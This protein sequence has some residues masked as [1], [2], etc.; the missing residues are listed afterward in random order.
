M[1]KQ[2]SPLIIAA[3]IIIA[4]IIAIFIPVEDATVKNGIPQEKSFI[5]KTLEKGLIS[6]VIILTILGLIIGFYR[7][8]YGE[9]M[10][11]Y[12]TLVGEDEHEYKLKRGENYYYLRKVNLKK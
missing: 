10:K 1:K 8:Q 5:Q 12:L 9:D 7:L 11:K 3:I 4:L 2:I 6:L